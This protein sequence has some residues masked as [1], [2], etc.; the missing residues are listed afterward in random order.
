VTI[1]LNN[2]DYYYGETVSALLKVLCDPSLQNNH[3]LT[4]DILKVQ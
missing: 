3:E 4:I 2:N 1:Q